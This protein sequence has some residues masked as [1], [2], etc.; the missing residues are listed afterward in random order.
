LTGINEVTVAPFARVKGASHNVV[1][2]EIK[3]TKGGVSPT[4]G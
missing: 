4:T 2:K 1:E 3:A